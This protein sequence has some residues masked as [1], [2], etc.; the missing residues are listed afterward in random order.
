MGFLW[1]REASILNYLFTA[2][3]FSYNK[4]SM[5][6]ELLISL[7]K[8][9]VVTLESSPSVGKYINNAL[10]FVIFHSR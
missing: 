1:A 5:T 2:R 4:K 9:P 3:A 7:W 8:Y 10:L 6:V